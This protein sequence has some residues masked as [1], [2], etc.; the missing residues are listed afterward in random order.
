[1]AKKEEEKDREG[2]G[3]QPSTA[4]RAATQGSTPVVQVAGQPQSEAPKRHK[5]KR[6]V[7]GKLTREAMVDI[8]NS[9]QSVSVGNRVINN[10]AELP[11]E[12]E[13]AGDDPAALDHALEGIKARRA[14]LDQEEAQVNAARS[15]STAPKNA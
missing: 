9:G 5:I 6:Y 8:I 3:S 4:P 15:K 12:A 1:M 14:L 11:S 10:L 13:L 2:Q 7:N